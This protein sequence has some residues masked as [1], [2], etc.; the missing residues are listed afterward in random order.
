MPSIAYRVSPQISIGAGLGIMYAISRTTVAISN[1]RLFDQLPDGQ[2]EVEDHDWGFNGKFGILYEPTKTTR[3]S[4]TYTTQTVLKFNNTLQWSG[5]GPGLQAFLQSRSLLNGQ[6]DL[7]VRTPQAVMVSVFHDVTDRLAL[8]ANVGWEQWSKF[9]KVDIG[10]VDNTTRSLTTDLG[11]KDT[12]HGALWA[13][14]RL[15]D[16]WL[17]S[18]QAWPTTVPWW[19]T[20]NRALPT[21]RW[22]LSLRTWGAVRVQRKD[23]GERRIRA[24]LAGQ[25]PDERQPRPRRR[26]CFG[27]IQGRSDSRRRHDP[28]LQVL[29]LA[30]RIPEIEGTSVE[31]SHRPQVSRS[32]APQ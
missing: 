20:I 19:T 12:W 4:V 3:V 26:D 7:G 5:L 21:R 16:P 23:H 8:L 10:I 1:Q 11:Y 9:G 29:G 28:A 18:R 14:Y 25:S 17:V 24:R 32:R 2:L 22:H 6:L 30:G 31:T 15:S 27:G 13:Q